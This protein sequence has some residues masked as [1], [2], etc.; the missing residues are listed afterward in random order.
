[1]DWQAGQIDALIVDFQAR[2]I[3]HWAVLA[4]GKQEGEARDRLIVEERLRTFPCAR[5]PP[6]RDLTKSSIDEEKLFVNLDLHALLDP[7]DESRCL[8]P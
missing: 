1:L 8:P 4:A 5:R 6:L 7:C 2:I 3:E